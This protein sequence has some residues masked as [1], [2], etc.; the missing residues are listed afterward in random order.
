MGDNCGRGDIRMWLEGGNGRQGVKMACGIQ[1]HRVVGIKGCGGGYRW[2]MITCEVEG[3]RGCV[4]VLQQPL[5]L[6][7]DKAAAEAAFFGSKCPK[8]QSF[9]HG[10]SYFFCHDHSF[11]VFVGDAVSCKLYISALIAS[12][13]KFDVTHYRIRRR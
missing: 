4:L 9:G 10:R 1:Q 8:R 2:G 7:G 3:S 13:K 11:W 12:T 5:A 6:V